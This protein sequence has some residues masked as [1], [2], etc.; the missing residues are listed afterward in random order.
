MSDQDSVYNEQP[1][2]AV[3]TVTTTEDTPS[4]PSTQENLIIQGTRTRTLT[5]KGLE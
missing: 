2:N 3:D 1:D 5:A 4:H